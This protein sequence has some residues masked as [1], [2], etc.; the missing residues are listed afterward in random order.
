M[1]SLRLG[2]QDLLDTGTEQRPI[3]LG[4]REVAP[5]I[6]QGALADAAA[7]AFREDQAMGDVA[8]AVGGS[9]DLVAA[10]EHG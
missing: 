4:E 10:D 5:E 6:E 7:A 3:G 1:F 8:F 2:T 9:A